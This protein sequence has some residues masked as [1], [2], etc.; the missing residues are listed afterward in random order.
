[1]RAG[2]Q[3]KLAIATARS[4]RPI[5]TTADQCDGLLRSL[6]DQINVGLRC[7]NTALRLLLG[8]VQHEDATRQ[9]D[10]IN[11]TKCIPSVI[12]DTGFDEQRISIH[13]CHIWH[14]RNGVKNSDQRSRSGDV[15]E[16]TRGRQSKSKFSDHLK[17]RE[18]G[19]I[20]GNKPASWVLAAV[21]LTDGTCGSDV[22]VR[23]RFRRNARGL[24]KSS[25]VVHNPPRRVPPSGSP[26]RSASIRCSTRLCLRALPARV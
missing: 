13:H 22:L 10:D 16:T 4:R 26:E 17:R 21:R 19:I 6:R 9:S 3:S 11:R 1:M 15:L 14:E 20:E 24:W 18:A 7:C 25:A 2:L 12:G 8:R 23:P 5:A